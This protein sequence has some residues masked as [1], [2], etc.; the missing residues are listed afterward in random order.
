MK[1]PK[2]IRDGLAALIST[3]RRETDLDKLMSALSE[4]YRQIEI[5]TRDREDAE[6]IYR[7][8]ILDST[9]SELAQIQEGKV[10]TTIAL[11]RA[12]ALV[13]TLTTRIAAVREA[14][15]RA[16]RQ[17]IH[18]DALAKVEAIKARLPGE[19]RRHAGALRGLLR[20]LAE[21]EVAI[22]RAGKEAPDFPA[23]ASPEAELRIL[24]GLPEDVVSVETV[25]LW[26]V[27][28]RTDPVP[29]Q[30][31]GDVRASAEHPGRGMLYLPGS[32]HHTAPT[33]GV[34]LTCT[35]RTFTRTRYREAVKPREDGS[36]LRAVALPAFGLTD[37]AFVTASPYRDHNGA[38]IE[39]ASDLPPPAPLDRPVRE[40][41]DLLPAVPRAEADVVQLRGAA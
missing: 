8:R 29:E 39:L 40:K 23:I 9:P 18:T 17:A 34:P 41:L 7:E 10:E 6:T 2:I 36:L 5:A 33:S 31:Q 3:A 21:A 4:A 28:G 35:L 15:A 30:R 22:A 32:A 20:D 1:A 12:E 19:Y 26:V 24:H 27:D 11:D 38:L 16:A 13:A 37:S 25:E 14:E